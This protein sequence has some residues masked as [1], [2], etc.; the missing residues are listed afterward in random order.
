MNISRTVLPK[1]VQFPMDILNDIVYS[2]AKYDATK[3]S[4]KGV[5]N[6]TVDDL[7]GLSQGRCKPRSPIMI[8]RMSIAAIIKLSDIAFHLTPP[9]GDL[10][11]PSVARQ[12]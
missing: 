9:I 8:Y 3:Y 12:S 5:N 6:T 4:D 7:S 10:L 2:R 11:E 1:T